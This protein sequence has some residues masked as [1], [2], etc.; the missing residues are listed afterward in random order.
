M[1]FND[2]GADPLTKAAFLERVAPMRKAF[3][4]WAVANGLQKRTQVAVNGRLIGAWSAV[5]YGPA[6]E[7]I[8]GFEA[9]MRNASVGLVT[10]QGLTDEELSILGKYMDVAAGPKGRTDAKGKCIPEDQHPNAEAHAVCSRE[11]GTIDQA[12]M[13]V[14]NKPCNSAVKRVFV[15]DKSAVAKFAADEPMIGLLQKAMTGEA[16]PVKKSGGMALWAFLGIGAV[17][18]AKWKKLF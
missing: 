9:T 1:Y 3:S 8:Q 11:D 2:F 6:V 12:C 13:A 14:Y 15:P 4:I 17:A 16:K 5:N 10:G 7:F 18:V